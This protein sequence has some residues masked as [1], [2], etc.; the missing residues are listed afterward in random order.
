[1]TSFEETLKACKKY[2]FNEQITQETLWNEGYRL[3]RSRW[4]WG[5]RWFISLTGWF[6]TQLD[7]VR[8]FGD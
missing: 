3:G 7:K 1:M 4:Y 5:P 8:S 6:N 2:D